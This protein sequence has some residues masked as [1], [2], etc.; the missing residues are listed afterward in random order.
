[1]ELGESSTLESFLKAKKLWYSFLEKPE[2]VH[3]ADAA[4]VTGIPLAKITKNLVSR[5]ESGEYVLLV[6]PGSRR[7]DLKKAAAALGVRDISIVPFEKAEPISGYPPG[8]T[9]TIGHKTM[10]RG[11]TKDNQ[12]GI[13]RTVLDKSLLNYETIFCGGGSRDK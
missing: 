6:I 10:L 4:G 13:S 9:P 7:V 5:T 11:N 3:T 2:T 1:M 8:G 12:C